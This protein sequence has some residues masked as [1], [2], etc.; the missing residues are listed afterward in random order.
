M[1][2]HQIK[3][4]FNGNNC[5]SK[6]IEK[7]KSEQQETIEFM[8]IWDLPLFFGRRGALHQFFKFN[9]VYE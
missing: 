6:M 4:N 8:S 3:K 2:T 7:R 9:N 5:K 1:N